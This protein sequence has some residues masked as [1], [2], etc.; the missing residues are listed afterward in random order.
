M[1][2]PLTNKELA[3]RIQ[4]IF[5]NPSLRQQTINEIQTKG[6]KQ[7]IKDNFSM[8]ASQLGS[9]NAIQDKSWERVQLAVLAPLQDNFDLAVHLSRP[10]D[11]P[12][13]PE[14][15]LIGIHCTDI[16]RFPHEPGDPPV[17]RKCTIDFGFNC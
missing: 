10:P 14:V 13:P 8:T 17:G 2:V 1:A 12:T 16:Y 7:Y 6:I 4:D 15:A 3:A 9:F 11:W 5:A